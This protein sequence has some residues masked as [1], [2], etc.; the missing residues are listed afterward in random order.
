MGK[1]VRQGGGRVSG[2]SGIKELVQ[3]KIVTLISR[4][5]HWSHFHGPNHQRLPIPRLH[6]NRQ[7]PVDSPLRQA[8]DTAL[9]RGSTASEHVTT[10][11]QSRLPSTPSPRGAFSQIRNLQAINLEK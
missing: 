6:R 8:Q 5:A 11:V 2:K 7:T 9:G 4:W 3:P 10:R 1:R